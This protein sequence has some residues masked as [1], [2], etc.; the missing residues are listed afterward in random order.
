MEFANLTKRNVSGAA[1]PD[2]RKAIGR[3]GELKAERS[4][5]TAGRRAAI[6][7]EIRRLN[8]QCERITQNR[9]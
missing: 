1:V 8:E 2:L 4:T 5:A 7:T 9:G 6:D 3:I